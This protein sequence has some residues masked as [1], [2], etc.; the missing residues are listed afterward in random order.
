MDDFGLGEKH[1]PLSGGQDG[2]AMRPCCRRRQAGLAQIRG[3]VSAVIAELGDEIWQAD[4]EWRSRRFP[5]QVALPAVSGTFQD[6]R[7]C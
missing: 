6:S 1:F 3:G 5:G 2:L 4:R 7:D